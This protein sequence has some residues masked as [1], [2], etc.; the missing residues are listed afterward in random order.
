ME[1]KILLDVS[2]IL[3]SEIGTSQSFNIKQQIKDFDKEL[4]LVKDLIGRVAFNHVEENQLLGFFDLAA[5]AEV[6]CARC[7]KAFQKPIKLN[8][9]QM[10][11]TNNQED[12][13]PIVGKKTIDIFPSIRQELLLNIP[14]KPICKKECKGIK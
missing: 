10:F 2:S 14:I 7:L 6:A 3:N 5:T 8:Y 1:Q 12:T 4:K 11:S 13:F 9:E